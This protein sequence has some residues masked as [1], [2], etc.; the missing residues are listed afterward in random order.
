MFTQYF[1]TCLHRDEKMLA[2]Y[3]KI[4]PC[5][6]ISLHNICIMFE[7]MLYHVWKYAYTMFQAYL[8]YVGRT[9]QTMLEYI[10]SQNWWHF[11]KMFE[12]IC[13]TWCLLLKMDD[14]FKKNCFKIV[15]NKNCNRVFSFFSSNILNQKKLKLWNISFYLLTFFTVSIFWNYETYES[16]CHIFCVCKISDSLISRNSNWKIPKCA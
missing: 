7:G 12:A 5:L 6:K 3:W 11:H 14:N 9:V 2:Q 8:H 4:I 1:E 16:F 15:K 10:L 13:S